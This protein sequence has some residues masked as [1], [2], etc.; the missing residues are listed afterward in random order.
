M[1]SNYYYL[2]S[3]L[4]DILPDDSRTKISFSALADEVC[5]LLDDQDKVLVQELRS[6][7]DRQNVITLLSGKSTAF[8][9]RG[10]YSREDLEREIKS[11]ETAPQFLVKY[12]ESHSDNAQKTDWGTEA[13]R[14]AELFYSDVCAHANPFIVAWFTFDLDIRNIMAAFSARKLALD[15]FSVTASVIGDN[16][17]AERLRK[18]TAAD[19]SLGGQFPWIEKVN[20]LQSG[21]LLAL[22]KMLDEIRWNMLNELTTFSYFEVETILAFLLKAGMVERWQKLDEESGNAR[23]DALLAE[24]GSK[25]AL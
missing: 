14:L 20:T 1:K 8:D 10:N 9:L 18:S 7:Y 5:E 21:S 25:L 16:E 13:V 23:F 17:V 15:G 24:L 11:P 6:F 2:V 3:G 19:F 12:L 22:E 4:P